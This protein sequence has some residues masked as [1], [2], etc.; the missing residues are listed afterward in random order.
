[1]DKEN[2]I[3]KAF[4]SAFEDMKLYMCNKK[5]FGILGIIAYGMESRLLPV[6]KG[7]EFEKVIPSCFSDG[8]TLT[9]MVGED[10]SPSNMIFSTVHALLHMMLYHNSRMNDRDEKLWVAAT[11]HVVNSLAK[12]ISGNGYIF[13]IPKGIIHFPEIQNKFPTATAEEVYEMLKV[14]QESQQQQN[15]NGTSVSSST[16]SDGGMEMVDVNMNGKKMSAAND[17]NPE[18]NPGSKGNPGNSKI[19]DEKGNSLDMSKFT[20]SSSMEEDVQKFVDGSKTMWNSEMIPKGDL[21][22][23][24]LEILNK[25]YKIELPWDELF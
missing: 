15:G 8:K 3:L 16:S 21:P 11:D 1:M 20:D 7:D 19:T 17:V 6:E 2:P 4:Q 12:E 10:V 25:L 14:E 5:E 18:K 22:G 9:Y 24:L 13:K 23:S